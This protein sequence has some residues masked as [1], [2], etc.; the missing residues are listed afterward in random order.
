MNDESYKP[1]IPDIMEIIFDVCYLVFALVAGIIFFA[2][3][4]G[5]T[6][7]ILYGILTLTLFGGDAFHL[8]PRIVRG[9]KGSNKKTAWTWIADFL[10]NHDCL[11]CSAFIHLEKYISAVNSSNSNCFGDL[12]F[13]DCKNY[14]LFVA[15]K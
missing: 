6:V 10:Y 2:K 15:A 1:R 5:K 11:L 12:D 9:L 13:C 7:F 3:S 14:N 4:Q 8:V